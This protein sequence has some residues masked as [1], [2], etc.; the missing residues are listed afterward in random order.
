MSTTLSLTESQTLAALRSLLL[1]I[2]PAGIE[3]VKAQDN[4]VAMP[5]GPNFVTMTPLSRERLATNVNSA[6][7]CA[8]NGSISGNTLTVASMILGAV[9]V[10]ATLFGPNVLP[11]TTITGNGTG[12]GGVGTYTVNQAQTAPTE[13][14]ACGTQGMLQATRVTIQVDV[15]GPAS[16]DNAQIITTAFRDSYAVDQFASSGYDVS[17]LYADDAQQMPL[18]DGESQFEERYVIKCVLQAN[19]IVSLPQ[20]YAAALNVNVIDVDA[21]YPA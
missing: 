20:Q 4:R 2:L 13:I 5:A 18:I 10:G 12:N 8:F 6:Q 16:A 11:G 3:V 17:P 9:T 7:D 21:T 19:P 14:M 15:Y 1:A